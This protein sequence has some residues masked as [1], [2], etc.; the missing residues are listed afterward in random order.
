MQKNADGVH[1][2]QPAK[3][4]TGHEGTH[5]PFLS[6][7]LLSGDESNGRCTEILNA[8]LATASVLQR[9]SPGRISPEEGGYNE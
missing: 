1:S 3:K 2:P 8:C 5:D 4:E 7:G 6:H 9:A